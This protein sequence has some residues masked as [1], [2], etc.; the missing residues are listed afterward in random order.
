LDVADESDYDTI[1][2][3]G[4]ETSD[5]Q[6]NNDGDGNVDDSS[7]SSSGN[8]ES[9]P[10]GIPLSEGGTRDDPVGIGE[11][12]VFTLSTFGDADDSVWEATVM[13]P[14]RD[15]TEAVLAENM[16]NDP[17]EEGHIFYGVP[18][19]LV[20]VDA[21]KVPLAPWLNLTWDIFGPEA[22]QIFA[23]YESYCGVIPG[24]FDETSEIYVGGSLSG[25]LCFSLPESEV[26]SGPLLSAE[27]GDDRIYFETSGQATASI[28]ASQFAGQI[29]VPDGSGE[30]GT[31]NNPTPMGTPS[32]ITVSTFGDADGSS[33]RAVVTGPAS[34]ITAAVLE[35]NQ[36]NDP[37]TDGY[38]FLGLPFQLELL[39][40]AKEP[41]A[42]WLNITWDIF[43][44]GS[45]RIYNSGC[46]VI[47]DPF[48]DMTEIFI[49]G[50]LE[51]TLCFAI[52]QTDSAT[53]PM[54]ST[55]QDGQ[56]TYWQ[57]DVTSDDTTQTSA[58]P[59]TTPS[60]TAT[61]NTPTA[62]NQAT[63]TPSPTAT[64]STSTTSPPTTSTT[65]PPTTT[66]SP[67]PTPE[68][69][70]ST[71]SPPAAP[72]SEAVATAADYLRY[73]GFSRQGL[74]DQLEYEGFTAAEA[75][76][77][78]DAQGADWNYQA[79]RVAESYLDYSGFSRQGLIDQLEY[80]GFTAAEATYGV[81]SVGL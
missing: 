33:W 76:Y 71:T 70:P 48:E 73:S 2:D 3:E 22:L 17:P 63:A 37:P 12:F 45:L 31:I 75:T 8:S 47:P 54:L 69:S 50:T 26:A 18:F 32:N 16:F 6:S 58:P 19:R 61:T 67:P 72:S 79:T 38:I 10:N 42:P 20:L 23:G 35:E 74:I 13:G 77:G 5:D 80:E 34:D 27:P 65:S 9:Q 44:T 68:T 4:Q 39:D 49:G 40:A 59:S 52:P 41:L 78:V 53:R 29:F 60:P 30:L 46:G 28:E 55:S 62:E 81:D 21:G 14:G 24:P 25:Y 11:G 7:S 66:T 57:L 64:T 1:D 15:I 43:G 56:R 51:G 36:F